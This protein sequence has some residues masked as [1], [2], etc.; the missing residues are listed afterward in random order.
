[1]QGSVDSGQDLSNFKILRTLRVFR[2][3]KLVRLVRASRI[4]KRILPHT[5]PFPSLSTNTRILTHVHTLARTHT[6]THTRTH[7][8]TH[9]CTHARAHAH[10]HAHHP[11]IY[12]PILFRFR[13]NTS[14]AVHVLFTPCPLHTTCPYRLLTACSHHSFTGGRHGW[15]STILSFRS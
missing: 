9:A 5:A 13:F 3:I 4:A 15:Q 1:M 11:P 10:A 12:P 8:H 2:L 7:A 14:Y 6:R